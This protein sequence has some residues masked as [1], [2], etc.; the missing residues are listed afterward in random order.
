MPIS[1]KELRLSLIWTKAFYQDSNLPI[2][3]DPAQYV[4]AFDQARLS[5]AGP[6]LLPWIAGRPQHF[7]QYYLKPVAPDNFEN[8]SSADARSCF[9]PLRVAPMAEVVA[10]DGAE[11]TF[12]GFCFPHSVAVTATIRLRPDPALAL[13]DVATLAIATRNA[14]YQITWK[15]KATHGT[16]QSLAEK[17]VN[18]VHALAKIAPAAVGTPLGYPITIATIIDAD[19]EEKSDPAILGETLKAL[20]AL[21]S[22]WR[23]LQIETPPTTADSGVPQLLAN[24][25]GRAIWNPGHFSAVEERGRRTANGCYHRNLTLATMQTAAL[26]E[27]IVRAEEVLADP[28]G[29]LLAISF[30]DVSKAIMLL[31]DL[32]E[33]QFTTYRSWSMKHQISFYTDR[34]KGVAA[35]L[36][37]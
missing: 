2:L 20:L 22:D 8:V 30:R 18:R 19:G 32:S 33:G 29:Q 4:P 15:D 11:A 26:T 10:R 23:T 6:W 13:A 14:D 21:R 25:R 3:A 9:V 31:N 35:K 24:D 34:I 17:V 7:W 1:V 5:A 12:E 36:G 37:Q 16:L 27:L 28:R